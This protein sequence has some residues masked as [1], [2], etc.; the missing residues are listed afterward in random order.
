MVDLHLDDACQLA[1]AS[2]QTLTGGKIE[3]VLP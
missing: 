1:N 3:E 2:F